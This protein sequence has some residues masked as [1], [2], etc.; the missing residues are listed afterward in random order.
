MIATISPRRTLSE[1]PRSACTSTLSV[2]Y[3]LTT[4]RASTIASMP[5]RGWAGADGMALFVLAFVTDM[6]GL[7]AGRAATGGRIRA[8]KK[9]TEGI[10]RVDSP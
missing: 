5:V 7:L 1:T 10:A 2:R 4:S 3:V 8:P 6:G 9:R